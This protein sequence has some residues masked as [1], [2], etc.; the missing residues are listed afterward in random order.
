VAKTL[1]SFG[2]QLFGLESLHPMIFAG[3]SVAMLLTAFLACFFPARGAA[4]LDP[5]EALRLNEP[6]LGRKT[7]T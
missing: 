7:G 1:G 3:S 5:M 6:M 4:K 2:N